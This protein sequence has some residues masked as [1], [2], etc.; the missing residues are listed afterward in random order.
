MKH[1]DS[2]CC[3]IVFSV[4]KLLCEPLQSQTQREGTL[5][6]MDVCMYSTYSTAN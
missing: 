2:F 6:T 4:H 5:I 1:L 3:L